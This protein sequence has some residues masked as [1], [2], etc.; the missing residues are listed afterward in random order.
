MA[1]HQVASI[2][3]KFSTTLL[4]S[5]FLGWLGVD[6]FY[7]GQG[8]IGFLKLITLGGFGIWWFIDI[9]IIASK[10]TRWVKYKQEDNWISKHPYY[11]IGIFFGVLIILFVISNIGSENGS[12]GTE[13]NTENSI[14]TEEISVYSLGDRVVVENFAYTFRDVTEKIYVGSNYFKEYPNGIF[15]VFDVEVENIGNKADYINNEIYIID[16]Q[17]REFEQDDGAW[18]YLEDNLIFEELNPGL[19]KKGQIIFDVPKD[20]DGKIGIKKSSWSSD[21]SAYIS[22]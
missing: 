7:L 15:L 19:T 6:R 8:F 5:L 13:I 9:F 1:H 22:W 17:N 16:N 12:Q 4:L 2:E 10:S 11:T 18:A 14:K 3:R 21:F 20:I